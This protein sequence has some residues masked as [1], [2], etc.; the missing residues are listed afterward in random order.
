MPSS[1]NAWSFSRWQDYERCP[2]FAKYKH[3]DRLPTEGGPAAARGTAIHQGAE[4]FVR[5]PAAKLLPELKLF[6]AKLLQLRKLRKAVQVEAMWGFDR[7]WQPCRWDDWGNCWLRV[8]MDASYLRPPTVLNMVD[9]KSGRPKPLLDHE[10]LKLY[11]V[12]GL[13]TYPHA[14]EAR[15]VLHYTDHGPRADAQLVVKRSE[16][17]HLIKFWE[18]RV[19]PMF[20]DRRFAP[21]PGPYCSWCDF[22]KS[23]GGPC[24]Y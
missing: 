21:R 22:A 23:K 7:N 24:K 16:E 10:Q 18:G 11:G 5:K 6:K 13:R 20:N 3:L 17:R 8:K 4:A 1:F 9:W 14:V 15:G 2:A 12:A 19:K